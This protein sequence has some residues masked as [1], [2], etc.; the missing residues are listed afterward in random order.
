MGIPLLS[1]RETSPQRR[2][3]G[4]PM[5]ALPAEPLFVFEFR[6]DAPPS[7]P[8]N[9][10][11]EGLD[12]PAPPRSARR[13]PSLRAGSIVRDESPADAAQIRAATIKLVAETLPNRLMDAISTEPP[14]AG[15]S[16]LD[17]S[18]RTDSVGVPYPSRIYAVRDIRGLRWQRFNGRG[19]WQLKY[20]DGV[21]AE[22]LPAWLAFGP[23]GERVAEVLEQ[24]AA[25]TPDR[26]QCLT[27][28]IDRRPFH[29]PVDLVA[30]PVGHPL[31]EAAQRASST[32][33]VWT[34][35][36][37]WAVDPGA[38]GHYYRG[39]YFVYNLS[40]PHWLSA[41]GRAM[42]AAILAALGGQLSQA[43]RVRAEWAELTS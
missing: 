37:G 5:P 39:C 28:P 6:G 24:A 19:F 29:I 13:P 30:D 3:A 23:N 11:G 32:A 8:S 27:V 43:D 41:M 21:V 36:R 15:P 34:E 31:R 7:P 40:D 26:V 2:G 1:N 22:E 33:M 35:N 18:L 12:F 16:Q 38:G 10:D 20:D 4:D 42:N 14:A 9:S 25:L 17:W